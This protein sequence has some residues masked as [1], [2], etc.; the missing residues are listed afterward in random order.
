MFYKL[1]GVLL[2]LT[3]FAGCASTKVYDVYPLTANDPAHVATLHITRPNSPWGCAIRSPVY[4]NNQ[5]V[6]RIGPGGLIQ[7]K[8]PAG[9]TS[10][11]VTT[12]DLIIDAKEGADYF[13]RVTMPFQ[14]WWMTPS[15][16]IKQVDKTQ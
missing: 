5:L 15:F 4:V 16:N 6:G 14:L 8:I 11:S 13:A 3:L 7:M 10:V 1:L 2:I 9:R 12:S